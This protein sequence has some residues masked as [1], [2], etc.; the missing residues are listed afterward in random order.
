ME[1]ARIIL[2]MYP[3]ILGEISL[4]ER[5]IFKKCVYSHSSRESTMKLCDDVLSMIEQKNKLLKLKD[6]V[7]RVLACLDKHEYELVAYKFFDIRPIGEFS[8]SMRSY[9]RKQN[10][11]LNRFSFLLDCIGLT[12]DVIDSEYSKLDLFKTYKLKFE[13]SKKIYSPLSKFERPKFINNNK[14]AS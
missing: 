1:N 5:K 8:Y 11:A 13:R 4:I 12:R 3:K 7:D 14:K 10:E 9:Y 6:L 2:T